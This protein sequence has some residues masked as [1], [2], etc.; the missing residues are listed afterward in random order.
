MIRGL[1]D[2]V[3]LFLLPFL[4]YGVAVVL[5][6]QFRI[7]GPQWTSGRLL[8]LG[9]A[10]LALV[11]LALLGYGLVAPR[12]AGAYLPAHLDGNRLVPGEL[13]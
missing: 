6:R 3:A 5:Q 12:H 1:A 9:V 11:M 2:G 13:R 4:L 10:G 7:V 8:V